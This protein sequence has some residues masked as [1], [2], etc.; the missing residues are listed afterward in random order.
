MAY[1]HHVGLGGVRIGPVG[2]PVNLREGDVIL[3]RED[4]ELEYIGRKALTGG[5]VG[6]FFT[7]HFG[8]ATQIVAGKIRVGGRE[9]TALPFLT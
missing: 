7:F 1:I 3:A 4:L 8:D 5:A 9:Q 6:N 2:L